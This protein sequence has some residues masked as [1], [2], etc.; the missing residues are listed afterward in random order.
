VGRNEGVS[1]VTFFIFRNKIAGFQRKV[2][3]QVK[4]VAIARYAAC[5]GVGSANLVGC[6]FG[7]AS[8]HIGVKHCKR[9][10]RIA[11]SYS[12][13]YKISRYQLAWQ[14]RRSMSIKYTYQAPYL[15]LRRLVILTDNLGAFQKNQID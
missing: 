7:G 11:G 4:H 2:E 13:P 6:S 12:C 15:E 9:R 10:I 14:I 3:Q 5:R 1:D 8:L